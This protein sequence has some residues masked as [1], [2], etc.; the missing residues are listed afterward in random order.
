MTPLAQIAPPCSLDVLFVKVL[1]FEMVVVAVSEPTRIA[2]PL[3]V[4]DLQFVK[5]E[6]LM[7]KTVF[8]EV[9]STHKAPP[10]SD[11]KPSNEQFVRFS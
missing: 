2:P 6:P 10:C 7:F 3:L 9:D 1:L 8:A 5:V 11:V 4:V